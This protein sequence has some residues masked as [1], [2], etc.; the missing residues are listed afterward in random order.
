MMREEGKVRAQAGPAARLCRGP[1]ARRLAKEQQ[2]AGDD[3]AES[4][5]EDERDPPRCEL[6]DQRNRL[7]RP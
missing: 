6:R 1:L 4:A 7:E 5:D 2:Q 3:E